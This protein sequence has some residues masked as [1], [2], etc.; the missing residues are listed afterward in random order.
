MTATADHPLRYPLAV[1]G[2]TAL[3]A[4]V[5]L[6]FADLDQFTALL[7]V[8]LALAAI[9]G[10]HL[11]KAARPLTVSPSATA[12]RVRQ[13]YRLSS[14]SWIEIQDGGRARWVPVYFDPA[15]IT[16]PDPAALRLYPSGAARDREPSGRLID[17]PTRPAPDGPARAASAARWRRRL[18]LDAQSLVAAPFIGLLWVYVMGGGI[19]GF[20]GA[21]WIGG[22]VA[23]WISAIRGSDPS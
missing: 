15:L 18:L 5:V 19:A 7:V 3:G 10:Y 11:W 21:A 22:L 8:L 23:M 14:R 12:R 16:A 20:L 17:N 6:P 4:A 2:A 9:T 1:T 13:E